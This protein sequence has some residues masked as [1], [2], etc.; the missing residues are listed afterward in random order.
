MS[1][2]SHGKGSIPRFGGYTPAKRVMM[3]AVAIGDQVQT[4][5]TCVLS[6]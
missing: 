3:Q 1:I 6:L 5:I 2:F 4:R